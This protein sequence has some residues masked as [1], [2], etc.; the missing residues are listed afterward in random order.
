M[1]A[2]QGN[3]FA[4]TTYEQDLQALTKAIQRH[5]DASATRQIAAA[6]ERYKGNTEVE[7]IALRF[8]CSKG[9]FGHY[10]QARHQALQASQS[11]ELAQ[12]LAACRVESGMT[13]ARN[14][15]AHGDNAGAIRVA[16][17]LYRYGPD[18][19]GAGLILAQ[20]YLRNNQP[21]EAGRI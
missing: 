9:D 8:E 3:A 19:Y 17:P 21:Q 13:D 20:A 16:Q 1:L 6:R 10:N 18:P 14:R 12:A 2:A 5:D 15:L 11:R 7:A 4:Q